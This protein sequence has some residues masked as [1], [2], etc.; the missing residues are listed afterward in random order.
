MGQGPA[1]CCIND[2]E[3]GVIVVCCPKVSGHPVEE[4]IDIRKSMPN[5][6]IGTPRLYDLMRD[7]ALLVDDMDTE[8][9]TTAETQASSTVT[10]PASML[11]SAEASST[12]DF[13]GSW[14]CTRVTGDVSNFMKDVGI[15]PKMREAARAARYGAGRQM[16]NIAQVGDAVVVQNILKAP[17]SMRFRIGAGPQTTLDQDGKTVRINPHWDGDTLCIESRDEDGAL[18]ARSRRYLDG[19]TMVLEL[20]SP[21]GTLVRRIFERR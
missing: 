20:A 21:K 14:L 15:A 3:D 5:K 2:S 1:T 6:H 17:V 10:R 18:I 12:V 7:K 19:E 8:D 11:T 9:S 16:Q 4:D 13:G